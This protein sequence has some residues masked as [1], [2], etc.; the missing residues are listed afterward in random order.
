MSIEEEEGLGA[1]LYSSAAASWVSSGSAM[2][3]VS[4]CVEDARFLSSSAL[5]LPTAAGAELAR[6]HG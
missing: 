5:G 4:S 2:G 3:R 1:G 6:L